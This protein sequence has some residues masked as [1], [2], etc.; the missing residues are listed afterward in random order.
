MVYTEWFLFNGIAA[1]RSP[2][3]RFCR[4]L[5]ITLIASK[6]IEVMI[7][8]MLYDVTDGNQFINLSIYQ[9]LFSSRLP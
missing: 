5:L 7:P 4:Q 9:S 6:V 3:Q 2:K 1:T 8:V